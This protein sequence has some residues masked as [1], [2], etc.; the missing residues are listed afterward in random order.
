MG[1]VADPGADHGRRDARLQRLPGGVHEPLVLGA[2]GAD[3]E[4]DGRVARPAVHEGAAV[5]AHQV[6]VAQPGGVRDAV[7][8]RVI[9]G[10]A[11]DR[12]E[13]GGGEGRAGS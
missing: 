11:E 13:R 1:D 4:A 8:D 7:H 12:G 2:G 5:D 6:A 3:R 9:D 10:G